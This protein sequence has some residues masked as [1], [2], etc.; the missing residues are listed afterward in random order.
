MNVLEMLDK[1]VRQNIPL[2]NRHKQV[3]DPARWKHL[4]DEVHMNYPGDCTLYH[5]VAEYEKRQL[6]DEDYYASMQGPRD[7]YSEGWA[8][9]D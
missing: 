8:S 4:F 9:C 7:W 5:N 3:Y 2:Q 1:F 6:E